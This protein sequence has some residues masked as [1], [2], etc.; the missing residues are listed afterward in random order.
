MVACMGINLI[1]DIAALKGHPVFTLFPM[2]AG[3]IY[4][5]EHGTLKQATIAFLLP[6]ALNIIKLI[7]GHIKL[8]DILDLSMIGVIMGWPFGLVNIIIS[9]ILFALIGDTWLVKLF[10]RNKG[11]DSYTFPYAVIIAAGA[12]VTYY[13]FKIFPQPERML[14]AVYS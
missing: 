11:G 1:T 8:Y 13:F 14:R 9:K 12:V 7:R 10:G 5:F 4:H 3:F 6:F 2:I